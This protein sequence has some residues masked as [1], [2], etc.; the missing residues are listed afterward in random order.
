TN[1]PVGAE[2]SAEVIAV[3]RAAENRVF[4]ATC[5]R[6]GEENGFQFIGLS[7]V[8]AP[9]GKILASAGPAETVIIADLN[10]EEARQKTIVNIPGKYET[11]IFES[12]RPELYGR[13]SD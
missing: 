2:I 12:R 7:K 8:I 4:V 3:A 10:L 1:W 9:S 6:V 13:I 11:A 5:N